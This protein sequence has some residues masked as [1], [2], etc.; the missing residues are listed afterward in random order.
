[1]LKVLSDYNSVLVN[2]AP[3]GSL[4]FDPRRLVAEAVTDLTE[5]PEAGYSARIHL[6]VSGTAPAAVELDPTRARLALGHALANAVEAA[7]DAEVRV[8]VEGPPGHWVTRIASE[9]P[10]PELVQGGP[11]SAE[12]PLRLLGNAMERRGLELTIVAIVSQ[13]FGGT[14]T[15]EVEPGLRSTLVL[16]WPTRPAP[17]GDGESRSPAR[18]GIEPASTLRV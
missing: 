2:E 7:G 11:L 5:S 1:M 3:A 4:T 13:R 15:L 16:D 10:P 9:Q 6:E 18:L 17:T 12:R 14:A 8:T